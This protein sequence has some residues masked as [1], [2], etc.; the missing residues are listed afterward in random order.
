MRC[1]RSE[2]VAVGWSTV[3][4]G[5]PILYPGSWG[6]E[7]TPPARG[8]ASACEAEPERQREETPPQSGISGIKAPSVGVRTQPNRWH[9]SQRSP[10][11]LERL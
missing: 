9:R 7:K 8:F 4:E 2:G 1:G 3:T 11:S 10:E 6:A 5:M